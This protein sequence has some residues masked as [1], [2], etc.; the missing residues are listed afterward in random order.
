MTTQLITIFG[1][2]PT[3]EATA[4]RLRA[5]GTPIRVVQR[6]RPENLPAGVEFMACDVLDAGQVHAAMAG[7]TQAVVTVGFE[8]KG[9]VWERAW[10][11]AMANLLAAAEANATRIVQV[12]NLYMYGPQTA[13]IREDMPLTRYGRKPRARAKATRMWM[14]AAQ[15]RRVW[16]ASL[17]APDFYGAGVDRSHIGATG[18][19]LVAQGKAANLLMEPDMPHAF[20]YVPDIARAA[21]TLLDAPDEDFNQAWHVPCAPTR[22]PRELLQIGAEAVGKKLKVAALPS[23]SL[24]VIGLVVP[25]IRECVEMQFTWNRPYHV[26]AGKFSRRFWSDATPFEVGIP[27]TVRAFRAS[28]EAG[29]PMAVEALKLHLAANTDRPVRG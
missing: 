15:T 22:T 6:Q 10:P 9:S 7:A 11:K 26:D 4:E 24:P 23:W 8:Y 17:R 20:A 21:V 13:P 3:G 18:L 12:D 29:K 1:Y 5:R 2:G 16:W 28:A 19:A 25:F 14:E 27:A